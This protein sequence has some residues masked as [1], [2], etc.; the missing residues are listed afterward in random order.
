MP[1]VRS[2]AR[3]L[4]HMLPDMLAATERLVAIDSGS[5]DADGVNEVAN[6]V[7]AALEALSFQVERRPLNGRG[8]QLTAAV[9]IGTGP[10]V[11]ILGHGDTVWPR[12][13]VSEW[14]FRRRDSRIEGPG[15][16]DM[17]SCLVMAIF[18]LR[19]LLENCASGLGGIRYLLV[20]DEEL[21]SVG[22]RAWIEEEAR[23]ADVC[24]ALEA[25]HPAGGVVTSRGAVGALLVRATGVSAHCSSPDRGASAVS[26]LAPLVG[27]LEA[28]GNGREGVR[29]SVGIFRG[30]AAR[31]VVPDHA[32]IH[33]DVRA[34]D[35]ATGENL[36]ALVT[37]T[38]RLAG[39]HD[40]SIEIEGG[41]TRPA[42]PRSDAT[43]WLYRVGQH[44]AA[45]L[46]TPLFERHERGGSDASFAAALG[47]P[48]LDGLGPICHEPCSRREWVEVDSIVQRGA[49]F[50]GLLAAIGEEA[51]TSERQLSPETGNRR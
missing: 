47:V 19:V 17:K 30:G 6:E 18:A 51:L 39:L 50:A 16:G 1:D 45:E 31:Q 49:L 41:I 9:D 22:S 14:P 20:P 48:T 36:V 10:V 40:V 21:G 38:V 3:R 12:G 7:G 8:D 23:T 46:R 13:T 44:L 15:V 37:E 32:E 35:D 33:L 28:L 4:E 29:V 34:Q 5:Y 43:S 2:Y 27:E 26:A 24:L 25:G 42:F 11:L